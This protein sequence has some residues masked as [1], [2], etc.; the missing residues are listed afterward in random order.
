MNITFTYEKLYPSLRMFPG[1]DDRHSV[2]YHCT[3]KICICKG[4]SEKFMKFFHEPGIPMRQTVHSFAVLP[5]YFKRKY[6]S[7]GS[8]G[9]GTVKRTSVIE[10][11]DGI[12]TVKY[13]TGNTALFSADNQ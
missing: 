12:R 1:N 2:Q 13:R 4:I 6:R 8:R 5:V 11:N 10:P 3:I 9:Q 7:G